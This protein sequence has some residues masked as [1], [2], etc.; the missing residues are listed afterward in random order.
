VNTITKDAARIKE[1]VE[2]TAIMKSMVIARKGRMCTSGSTDTERCSA[3][4]NDDKK[5]TQT[6]LFEELKGKVS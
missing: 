1:H 3:K 4:F 5:N 2:G 6:N